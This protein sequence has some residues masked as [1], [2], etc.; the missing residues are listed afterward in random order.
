MYHYLGFKSPGRNY[1]DLLWKY[2]SNDTF[3]ITM[4][5][6]ML[7]SETCYVPGIV[8]VQLPGNA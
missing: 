2:D 5:T 3:Q 8:F 7:Y 4:P 1:G 6:H